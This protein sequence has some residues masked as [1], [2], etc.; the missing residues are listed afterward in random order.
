MSFTV[1]QLVVAGAR[2][3]LA[4][5]TFRGLAEIGITPLA[6]VDNNPSLWGKST[7]GVKV[8]QPAE[9]VCCYPHATFVAAVHNHTP[10]RRQLCQLGAKHVI[11]YA[12]LFRQYP[13]VFLP[14]LAL[15]V[16]SKIA[17]NGDA[18]KAASAVWADHESRKLY[19]GLTEWFR[20]LEAPNMPPPLPAP[21][22]YFPSFLRLEPDE[23]FVDCGAFDGDTLRQYLR[24]SQE[25]FAHL[26]AIEPDPENF[27]RLRAFVQ[28][29]PCQDR[30][31]LVQAA[32]TA[33]GLSVQ[34]AASGN[35][36]AHAAA[37]G[38]KPETIIRVPGMRLDDLSPRPTFVKMDIEGSEMSAIR[39][40]ERLLRGG[41]AAWAI[42][43]YHRVEDFWRIPL[44]LH[45][46]APELR[47][48]LRHYAEDYAETI[49]YAVPPHRV[50]STA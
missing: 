25:K 36:G 3:F 24:I 12:V 38:E 8:M 18:I 29:L 11:S 28:T 34:F 15:D 5:H 45:A 30:I 46:A 42:T 1:E 6:A 37:G 32:T 14:Y 40:G 31:T 49:C 20:T 26:V 2:G 44:F 7:A 43:L 4:E 33:D 41:Q 9:A 10:L 13:S 35:V 27:T 16:P 21:E 22:T 48:F 23:V 19:S 17:E 39:S 47:L 50:T